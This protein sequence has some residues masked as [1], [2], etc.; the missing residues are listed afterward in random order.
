MD[1]Y[2]KNLTLLCPIQRAVDGHR[3]RMGMG[4][5]ISIAIQTIKE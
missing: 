5:D 4:V 3:A 1:Q 2:R